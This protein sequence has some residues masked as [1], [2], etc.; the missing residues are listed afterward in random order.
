MV[1]LEPP[2]ELARLLAEVRWSWRRG[3]RPSLRSRARGTGLASRRPGWAPSNSR[4][5]SAPPRRSTRKRSWGT[6][7]AAGGARA[8]GRGEIAG[9]AD[10]RRP[11]PPR[12]RRRSGASATRPSCGGAGAT[13]R[14]AFAPRGVEHGL[15]ARRSGA[16]TLR[17]SQVRKTF[18]DCSASLLQSSRSASS[19]VGRRWVTGS[20]A[21]ARRAPASSR[22]RLSQLY[23]SC[24]SAAPRRLFARAP[25]AL[26][27]SQRTPPPAR[28]RPRPPGSGPRARLRRRRRCP[29][30]S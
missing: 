22:A 6:S 20:C 21:P 29:R 10:R 5:P 14:P 11:G 2:L 13:R 4:Q 9:G 19:S 15:P 8:G 18:P 27:I 3:T 23:R 1:P 16:T 30:G 7:P 24:T 25:P 26:A 12:R 28:P 17:H